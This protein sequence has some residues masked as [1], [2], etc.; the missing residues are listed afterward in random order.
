MAGETIWGKSERLLMAENAVVQ[1]T[2]LTQEF[3]DG[4]R[5]GNG[6]GVAAPSSRWWEVD[7]RG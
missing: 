6:V 2:M 5:G 1:F 7:A 3:L 4:L